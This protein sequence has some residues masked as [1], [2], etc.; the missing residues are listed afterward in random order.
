MQAPTI[1]T[2]PLGTSEPYD[3]ELR[4]N[5]AAKDGSGLDVSLQIARKDGAAIASPP[6]VAWLDQAAGRVRVTGLD[7]LAAGSYV[8]R[9]QLT[10]GAAQVGFVPNGGQ[11]DVWQ[12]VTP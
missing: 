10:D 6:T 12:V 2:I 9:F 1:Y 11:P 7:G 5:G 8:V 3:F 4:D